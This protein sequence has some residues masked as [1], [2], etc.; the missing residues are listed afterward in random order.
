MLKK[1]I[2]A[3][4]GVIKARK[5]ALLSIKRRVKTLAFKRNIDKYGEVK[6]KLIAVCIR[7]K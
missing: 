5:R 2:R 6:A 3:W 4:K 1:A 7:K